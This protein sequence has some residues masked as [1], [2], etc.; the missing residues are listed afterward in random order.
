MVNFK[1]K[2][3][4]PKP[5][6]L[7]RFPGWFGGI[8]TAFILRG[9]GALGT[10]REKDKLPCSCLRVVTSVILSRSE[11]GEQQISLEITKHSGD[12]MSPKRGSAAE[13]GDAG[14][15]KLAPSQLLVIAMWGA[16]EP[17]AGR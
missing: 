14:V 16:P 1:R 12:G 15:A 6:P 17:R 2:K 10:G 9:S 11:P 5:K 13:P 4:P 3:N 7:Q 8:L